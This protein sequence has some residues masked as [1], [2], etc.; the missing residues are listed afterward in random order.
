MNVRSS[1]PKMIGQSRTVLS[2]PSVASFERYET[3]GTLLDALIYVALAG[4]ITGAA[5]LS[6]GLGGLIRNIL[7]TLFGFFVFTY[8]VHLIGKRQGGTGSLDEVAYTFAL[9][10]APLSVIFSVVTLILAITLVG[11]VLVPLVALAA[12]GFNVFFAF[13][14][15]Q[16]SM[17][18]EAG[19]TTLAVLLMAAF[20]AF[21]VNML[22]TA[23]FL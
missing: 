5:G 6:E 9:F 7:V 12:L 18:L 21:I 13:L 20:G 14:A 1:I 8:L 19:S 4:A 2:S 23:I 3:E 15:V 11:L 10:W 22:V 16:S 17:N